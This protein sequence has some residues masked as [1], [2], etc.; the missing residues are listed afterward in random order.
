M[1]EQSVDLQDADVGG[2]ILPP[3]EEKTLLLLAKMD[4]QWKNRPDLAELDKNHIWPPRRWWYQSPKSDTWEKRWRRAR[5]R[6]IWPEPNLKT[7]SFRWVK[8]GLALHHHK[9]VL[10][11]VGQRRWLIGAHKPITNPARRPCGRGNAW[12]SNSYPPVRCGQAR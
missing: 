12:P 7:W 3:T 6:G 1:V 4:D 9:R 10:R 8:N 2:W 5:A 11:M